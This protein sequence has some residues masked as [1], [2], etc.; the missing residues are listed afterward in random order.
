MGETTA[1]IALTG[2]DEAEA[3]FTVRNFLPRILSIECNHF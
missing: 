2:Q 3:R 1:H